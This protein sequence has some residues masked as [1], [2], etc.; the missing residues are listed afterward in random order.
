M[1]QQESKLL[2]HLYDSRD[3]VESAGCILFDFHGTGFTPV[4]VKP[5]ITQQLKE[6]PKV[7]LL[8]HLDRNRFSPSKGRLN[9]GESRKDA[10]I[11]ET[12]EE[13]GFRCSLLPITLPSRATHVDP[14]KNRLEDADYTVDEVRIFEEASDWFMCTER[15]GYKEGVTKMIWWYVGIVTEGQG[16]ED[17]IKTIEHGCKVVKVPMSEAAMRCFWKDD[18]KVVARAVEIVKATYGI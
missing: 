8:H 5:G 13:T 4:A 17:E 2:Q 18:G 1:T 10:A 11:R 3:L 6:E 14:A 16:S 9:N 15:N 12:Y 7:V